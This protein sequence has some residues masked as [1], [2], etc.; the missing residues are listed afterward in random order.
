MAKRAK[1][2][3]ATFGTCVEPFGTSVGTG[4]GTE[5][6]HREP[7]WNSLACG[8]CGNWW[9]HMKQAKTGR[10]LQVYLWHAVTDCSGHARAHRTPSTAP[11]Y[12]EGSAAKKFPELRVTRLTCKHEAC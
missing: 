3:L 11:T 8:T 7:L 9:N 6:N 10:T 2:H 5:W 4:H 1:F 12:K